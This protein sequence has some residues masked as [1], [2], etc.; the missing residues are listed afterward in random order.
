MSKYMDFDCD[1]IVGAVDCNEQLEYQEESN[2]FFSKGSGGPFNGEC[3]TCHQNGVL[4]HHIKFELGREQ[5]TDTTY[6]YSGCPMLY[7]T[8]ENGQETGTWTFFYDSTQQVAWIKEYGVEEKKE[9]GQKVGTHYYF[10]NKGDTAVVE[11]YAN[12]LLNGEKRIYYTQN[13]IKKIINYRNGMFSGPSKTYNLEGKLLQEENYKLIN[14]KD[15]RGKR[16]G[17]I[18]SVKNGDFTY[19]YDDGTLLKTEQWKENKKNGQFISYYYDGSVMNTGTYVNGVKEGEFIEYYNNGKQK[20]YRLFE[21]KQLVKKHLF[22]EYGML[23]GGD[24][25][26]ENGTNEDDNLPKT[27]K[28][29]KKKNN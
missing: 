2:R 19:Y 4:E 21:N 24:P 14:E 5:G 23:I 20:S 26:P 11:N 25:L 3:V 22:D 16:T 7:R 27:K 17:K 13:R 6:Y 18:I 28:K 15:S 1:K 29:K 12:N 9:L 10:D 8:L